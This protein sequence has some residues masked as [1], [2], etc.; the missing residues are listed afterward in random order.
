LHFCHAP[1]SAPLPQAPDSSG[2]LRILSPE[3]N[4]LYA[5]LELRQQHPFIAQETINGAQNQFLKSRPDSL[6]S[7]A[8]TEF[9]KVR[10]KL[11]VDASMV[12]REKRD[13]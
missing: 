12:H 8:S 5:L 2:P 11:E 10:R 3:C 6:E 9:L 7:P 1:F 13:G 4:R